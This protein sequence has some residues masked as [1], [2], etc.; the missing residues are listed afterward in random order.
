MQAETVSQDILLMSRLLVLLARSHP[1]ELRHSVATGI[2]QTD[3]AL[4]DPIQVHSVSRENRHSTIDFQRG[5]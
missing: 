5:I 4:L 3:D 2:T 1:L